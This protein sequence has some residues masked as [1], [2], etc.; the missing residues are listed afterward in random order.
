MVNDP[1]VTRIV[2]V[3]EHFSPIMKKGRGGGMS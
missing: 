3:C 1:F 2:I